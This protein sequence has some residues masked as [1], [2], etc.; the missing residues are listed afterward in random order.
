MQPILPSQHFFFLSSASFRY[1]YRSGLYKLQSAPEYV[2]KWHHCLFLPGSKCTIYDVYWED[3]VC[4]SS[5]RDHT[6]T[7]TTHVDTVI[8]FYYGSVQCIQRQKCEKLWTSVALSILRRFEH[9]KNWAPIKDALH[10]GI[11]KGPLQDT[12]FLHKSKKKPILGANG[13]VG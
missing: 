12:S 2:A 3:S 6:Q 5:S 1:P 10:V 9:N 7:H 8:H 11:S 4:I 13:V